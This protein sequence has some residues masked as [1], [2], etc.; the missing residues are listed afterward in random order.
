MGRTQPGA[1]VVVRLDAKV[2]EL[3]EQFLAAGSRE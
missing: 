2:E 1:E 3:T